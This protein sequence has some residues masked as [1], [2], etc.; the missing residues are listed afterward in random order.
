MRH[1]DGPVGGVKEKCVAAV[2]SL[3]RGLHPT[4]FADLQCGRRLGCGGRPTVLDD[5]PIDEVSQRPVASLDVGVGVGSWCFRHQRCLGFALAI[6]LQC[7]SVVQ[8]RRVG[9][10]LAVL[11]SL[12]RTLDERE[13]FFHGLPG[14][15]PTATSPRL[16]ASGLPLDEASSGLQG[17]GTQTTPSLVR[18]CPSCPRR[19]PDTLRRSVPGDSDELRSP[20]GAVACGRATQAEP[21][22]GR[23]RR[24]TSRAA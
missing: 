14:V 24:P 18:L 5:V 4:I 13:R 1:T 16:A 21:P 17:G 19:R 11:A 6:V 20:R 22:S 15:N 23:G 9:V 7:R 10:T 12:G 3:V 8:G 2:Q